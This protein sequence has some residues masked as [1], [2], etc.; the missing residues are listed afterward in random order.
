VG[1]CGCPDDNYAF[2]FEELLQINCQDVFSL[3]NSSSK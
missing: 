2:W 3:C 1:S